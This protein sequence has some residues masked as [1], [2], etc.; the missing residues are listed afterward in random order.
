MK[1]RIVF[2][3]VIAFLLGLS[4]CG[5]TE[6]SQNETR[7]RTQEENSADAQS[8]AADSGLALSDMQIRVESNGN[9]IVFE[10]NDSQAACELYEQL[11]LSIEVEDYSTNEKI[12]YPTQE[13]DV[14]DAPLAEAGAGT[15]AYYAPWG[16]VV[17]FYEDFGG[18]GG[19]YELGEA[20]SGV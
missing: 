11:P 7:S 20:V 10:L 4:A 5:Q 1:K 2:L 14:S 3:C 17:M 9:T 15:L 16:D 8:E 13:L 6:Q 12:F 18:A 19:L